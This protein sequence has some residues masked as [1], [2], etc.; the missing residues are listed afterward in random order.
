V[1]NLVL[2]PETYAVVGAAIAVHRDLGPGFL[3]AVYQEALEVELRARLIPFE[4]E[5]ALTIFYRDMPLRKGYIADFLCYGQLIVELKAQSQLTGVETAQIINY[6][7]ASRLQVGLLINFG[8][9]GKL[10]WKRMVR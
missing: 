9:T 8:S 7:K 5:K 2:G 1:T 3:E 4:R 10:Q 6:L